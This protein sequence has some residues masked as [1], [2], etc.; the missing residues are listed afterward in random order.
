MLYALFVL[1]IV[2]EKKRRACPKRMLKVLTKERSSIFNI[3]IVSRIYLLYM[4]IDRGLFCLFL[5]A[6]IWVLIFNYSSIK[7]GLS[8]K[9]L[10]TPVTPLNFYTTWYCLNCIY[11]PLDLFHSDKTF[12]VVTWEKTTT[13]NDMLV[14]VFVVS[15]S[16][17]KKNNKNS[18]GWRCIFCVTVSEVTQ[19]NSIQ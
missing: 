15:D 8:V 2:R 9:G 17:G 13:Q 12:D 7:R 14:V 18:Y 6:I 4:V 11:R 1:C 19:T 3:I 10:G 5:R 16:L